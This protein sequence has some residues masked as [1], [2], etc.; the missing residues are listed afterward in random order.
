MRTI[1]LTT[2]GMLLAWPAVAFAQGSTSQAA[3]APTPSDHGDAATPTSGLGDIVVT[4]QRRTESAQRAAI[5]LS[6]ID[7]AALTSAGVT[8][9]SRLNELA[10]ALSIEPSSTGNLIFLRGVGNFTVTAFSDPAI[11]FNYD[12]VYVGRPTSTTG[13]FY[14][15]QRV[16]V[17]KGPQGILY[18]RN[19]TGGAINIIPVQPKIG[20]LSGYATAS[21]GNYDTINAEGAINVP[22]GDHGA[23]RLSATTSNHHGY[24]SD[25]TDDDKTVALRA[26]MKAELTPNLTVRVSGDYA[27]NYGVGTS[28]SYYGNY[29]RNPAVP[30][31]ATPIPGSNYYNFTP[32]TVAPSQGVFS[33]ASQAYRQGITF[34]PTGRKLDALAP[35]PFQ[36]NNFYGANAEITLK[37]EAG[38]FTVI[39]AWRYSALDYLSSAGAFP[40]RNVERDNQ[41]SVEARFAG[42]RISIFDYTLGAYFYDETIHA[43]TDLSNSNIGIQLSPTFLTKSYAGFGRLTANFSDKLRLVGGLRYTKDDKGFIYSATTAVIQCL[44]VNAFGAPNCPTAPLVPLPFSFANL[45]FPFPAAGGAAIPVF[46][47]RGPP[48]YVIARSDVAFNRSKSSSRVTYRGAVEFD[49]LPRSLLYAS[50][51]TGYRSGGFSAAAGFENFDPEYITA[52]TAGLKN[53]FLDNRIQLNLEAFL[54]NY[55]NQQINHVGLDGNSRPA[56]YTQNAGSSRIKGFEADGRFLVTPTTLISADVQYLDAKQL[57]FKYLAGPGAPP[58]TGCAVTYTAANKSP[59]LIDCSGQTSYNSPKWTVNLAGQ[60]T[61]IVGDYQFVAGVDTQYKGARNIGFAYLPQQ[62]LPHD[63]TTNVQLRFG[64]SNEHWAISG[65]VRNIE[66]NRIPIYSSTHPTALILVAGTTAPRTYGVQG[67]VK[68]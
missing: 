39:P 22:V 30:L 56:N 66:N 55:K 14:D 38:T 16:E 65:Y 6:V 41:F 54:W 26:Q 49:V 32:A 60:Q 44:A 24:L 45:P 2:A 63:W 25:G 12:G 37:T 21:Y 36:H 15:L 18:G 5:P 1:L 8:E 50:V 40:Y 13:V 43:A 11:A 58:L 51:E 53:R 10:P 20:E 27:R 67:S 35:Y 31:S 47:T 19:A 7:G 62:V 46:T 23:V 68:F 4:A 52:Y 42:K 9:A 3:P 61:V 33:P 48:N 64:P 34:G 29:T 28:V 57:S 59:Y 17:L